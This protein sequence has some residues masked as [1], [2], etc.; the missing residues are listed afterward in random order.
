MGLNSSLGEAVIPLA[1][2]L[3]R[4]GR[5]DEAERFLDQVKEEWA[6]GDVSIEAPRLA[7]RARLLAAG[8]WHEHAERAGAR[9]LRLARRTDWSCLQVDVMLAR[10]EVMTLADRDADAASILRESIVLAETKGY[11]AGER[12][13]RRMLSELGEETAAPTR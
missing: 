7:V 13:A 6:S 11:L 12:H 9:A 2:A 10:A 8:G 4:Q 5:F 1:D 3:S